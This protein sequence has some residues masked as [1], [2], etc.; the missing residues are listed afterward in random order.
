MSADHREQ[1]LTRFPSKVLT[2]YLFWPYHRFF[3]EAANKVWD[4]LPEHHFIFLIHIIIYQKI[5]ALW[6]DFD[7]VYLL[8][9]FWQRSPDHLKQCVESTDIW[10]ML[11]EIVNP[12]FQ[13]EKVLQASH[14]RS[15]SHA[16]LCKCNG[17]SY[18][19]VLIDVIWD[20]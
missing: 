7:Y 15:L 12:G 13:I 11:M 16:R 1:L 8:R 18:K 14:R 6:K 2:I 10:E 3:L 19:D 4:C 5:V 17:N 9:Q 20:Q